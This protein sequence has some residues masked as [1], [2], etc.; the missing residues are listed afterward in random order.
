MLVVYDDTP[1]R[2]FDDHIALAT[3]HNTESPMRNAREDRQRLHEERLDA[4]QE[5]IRIFHDTNIPEPLP[6]S[7]IRRAQE[8]RADIEEEFRAEVR[9]GRIV[10]LSHVEAAL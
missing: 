4:M 6:D 5:P 3:N 1:C 7:T 9:S 8:A 2:Y 10:W